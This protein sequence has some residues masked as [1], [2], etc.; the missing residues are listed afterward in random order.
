MGKT[1][2][3]WLYPGPA[4]MPG[5]LNAAWPAAG[6]NKLSCQEHTYRTVLRPGILVRVAMADYRVVVKP[7]GLTLGPSRTVTLPGGESSHEH[8]RG[9]A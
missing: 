9:P 1:S 4:G 6:E 2:V 8:E 7:Y 3:S 5:I